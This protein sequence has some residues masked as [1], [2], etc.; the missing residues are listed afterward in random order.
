MPVRTPRNRSS[1]SSVPRLFR[2]QNA[3][4]AVPTIQLFGDIG[5]SMEPDPFWGDE[6]GAGTFKEFCDQ[7]AA[8]GNVPALRVEIHSFGGSSFIGKAIHAKLAEHPARKTAVIY[9][10][11]ASAATYP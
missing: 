3:A 1:S 10:I 5:L 6:G 9:G 8:L 7:L 2:I 11:C 4:G